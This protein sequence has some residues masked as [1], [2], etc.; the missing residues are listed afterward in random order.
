MNISLDFVCLNRQFLRNVA[1]FSECNLKTENLSL[2]F[3]TV[4]WN[5][6]IFTG[7]SKR[8]FLQYAN[9]ANPVYFGNRLLIGSEIKTAFAYCAGTSMF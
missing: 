3:A 6:P 4:H 8:T 9:L 1:K 5:L 7:L 2:P